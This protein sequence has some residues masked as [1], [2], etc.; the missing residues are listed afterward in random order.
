M[1]ANRTAAIKPS[2]VLA[3]TAAHLDRSCQSDP[4]VALH[5]KVSH[6]CRTGNKLPEQQVQSWSALAAA[7]RALAKR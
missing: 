2:G 4:E 6:L 7:P 1:G 5:F 3:M